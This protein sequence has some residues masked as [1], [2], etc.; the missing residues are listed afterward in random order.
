MK[1]PQCGYIFPIWQ[2]VTVFTTYEAHYGCPVPGHTPLRLDCCPKCD[3]ED[4][5]EYLPETE[6][7]ADD[8]E[9]L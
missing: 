3:C 1:C 7:E 4:L 8:L 5:E 6:E 9:T 2:A